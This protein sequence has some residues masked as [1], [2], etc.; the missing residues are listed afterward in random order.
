MEKVEPEVYE[1]RV[2]LASGAVLVGRHAFTE[3][4]RGEAK[5]ALLEILG[6]MNRSGDR[7]ALLVGKGIL[8]P[9]DS[10]ACVEVRPSDL[11]PKVVPVAPVSASMEWEMQGP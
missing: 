8:V 10:V 1:I 11:L 5:A 9:P 6:W 4:G 3:E 7:P 2:H